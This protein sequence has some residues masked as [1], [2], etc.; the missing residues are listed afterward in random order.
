MNLSEFNFDE[1]SSV[2]GSQYD[3]CIGISFLVLTI[4][5]L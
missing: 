5:G 4:V 2:Y 1:L 3:L